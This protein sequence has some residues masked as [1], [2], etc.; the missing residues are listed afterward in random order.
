MSHPTHGHSNHTDI[1]ALYHLAFANSEFEFL[2]RM[3]PRPFPCLVCPQSI[4]NGHQ[5]LV[6]DTSRRVFSN[7]TIFVHDAQWQRGHA[8]R[9]ILLSPPDLVQDFQGREGRRFHPSS[10]SS[11]RSLLFLFSIRKGFPTFSCFSK[12]PPRLHHSFGGVCA[13]AATVFVPVS[14]PFGVGAPLPVCAPPSVSAIP[15]SWNP[16]LEQ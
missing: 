15:L 12:K 3:N 13:F 2:G 16:L 6:L 10:S 5:R 11:T 14:V 7:A 8:C 4:G 1:P 9:C